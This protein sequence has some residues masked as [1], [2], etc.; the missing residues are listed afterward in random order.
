M[1]AW[2][3]SVVQTTTASTLN[4][5]LQAMVRTDLAHVGDKA[6]TIEVWNYTVTRHTSRVPL[7]TCKVASASSR[8][9][10]AWPFLTSVFVHTQ[11]R[12]YLFAVYTPTSVDPLIDQVLNSIALS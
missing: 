4:V 1:T 10:Q 11:A 12:N 6:K 5:Q 9:D 8:A 3:W 7:D 2:R